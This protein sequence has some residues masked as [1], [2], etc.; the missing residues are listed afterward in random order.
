MQK[1]FKKREEIIWKIEEFG[2]VE[3]VRCRIEKV[4][5]DHYVAITEGNNNAYDNIRLWIEEDDENFLKI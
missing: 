2:E 4:F 5:K 3:L 1:K